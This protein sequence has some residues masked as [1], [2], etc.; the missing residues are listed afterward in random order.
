MNIKKFNDALNNVDE[1]FLKIADD[2]ETY[3]TN[4][5]QKSYKR[6]PAFKICFA[7][8]LLIFL[9]GTV[10]A[11]SL[12]SP[13]NGDDFSISGFYNGNG[14]VSIYIE[15]KSDNDLELNEDLKIV[16]WSTNEEVKKSSDNVSFSDT[17]I[18]AHSE[19]TI[20][21]D[22]S[23]MYNINILEKPLENDHYYLVMTNNNFK[24]G[25]DYHCT[26]SFY[27]S[28]V[29]EPIEKNEELE[30]LDIERA[31]NNFEVLE[32]LKPFFNEYVIDPTLRNEKIEEYYEEV[33]RILVKEQQNG[34][35]FITTSNPWLFVSKPDPNVIFDER[36]SNQL[37]YQL[38]GEHHY[39]LSAYNIPVGSNYYDDCMVLSTYIPQKQN[40]IHDTGGA[41]IQLAY[42]YQYDINEIKK[43]NTYVFIYGRILNYQDLEPFKI[44]EDNQYVS[45]NMTTLFYNNLETHIKLSTQ[46][47]NVYMDEG[48]KTRIYNVYHYLMNPENMKFY[49]H[50]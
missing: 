19:K 20:T 16:S 41:E 6:L 33:D 37:Q 39:S 50:R 9:I 4:E 12:F 43:E 48:T 15:N 40:D 1:K 32:E 46:G 21:I 18:K 7:S 23:K 42:I 36:V 3:T 8:F 11:L 31:E 26:I 13:L 29:D 45:Y 27:E 17:L 28:V 38:I 5:N 30:S 22:L 25:Y 49:Y 34:K 24:H 35:R 2:Y 10:Y 44:Y 47:Q 14:I